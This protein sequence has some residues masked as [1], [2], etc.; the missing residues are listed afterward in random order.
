MPKPEVNGPRCAVGVLDGAFPNERE[1]RS[2][3]LAAVT[4]VLRL[5]TLLACN[6][7]T[8]AMDNPTNFTTDFY[9]CTI[10]TCVNYAATP[11]NRNSFSGLY[12]CDE[13]AIASPY[14]INL[15]C[16][17]TNAIYLLSCNDCGMQYV[18]ETGR[19]VHE[20]FRE[21]KA[22]SFSTKP[23]KEKIYQHFH[24]DCNG[25]SSTIIEKISDTSDNIKM[26]RINL[27]D[28]KT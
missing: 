3:S 15:N 21:H 7:A 12:R 8:P 13:H 16:K 27:L 5:T 11:S 23:H 26:L 18:G 4:R 17:T 10:E 24:G 20:R 22:K 14:N 9:A 19:S 28:Q 2:S 1:V 6:G 25:F